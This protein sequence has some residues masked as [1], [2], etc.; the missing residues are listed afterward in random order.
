[1]LN[2]QKNTI[3][4]PQDMPIFVASGTDK[5]V[6]DRSSDPCLGLYPP[7]NTTN[8]PNI[9]LLLICLATIK[10]ICINC[11]WVKFLAEQQNWSFQGHLL[12]E[13]FL[14]KFHYFSLEVTCRTCEPWRSQY[15]SVIKNVAKSDINHA[16]FG[17][18]EKAPI[19]DKNSY[20]VLNKD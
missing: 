7:P 9:A 6:S 17:G 18:K 14:S 8:W 5:A 11:F 16:W 4:F 12:L 1:M 10:W 3:K 13:Y 20:V 15:F 19:W 2:L